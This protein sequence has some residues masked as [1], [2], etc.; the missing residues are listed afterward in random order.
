MTRPKLAK[1]RG[2]HLQ[3][4][5][6]ARKELTDSITSGDEND[7]P[8]PLVLSNAKRNT[9]KSVFVSQ[10]AE[11][12]AEIA[13]NA[14]L[15]TELESRVSRL[16][17]DLLQFHIEHQHLVESLT[18]RRNDLEAQ[19]RSLL[20][21]TRS[22]GRSLG[23]RKRKAET[24]FGTELVRK[25]KRIKRLENERDVKAAVIAGLAD[26]IDQQAVYIE[27]LQAIACSSRRNSRF[28]IVRMSASSDHM[29]YVGSRAG[30]R[31][32]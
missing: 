10:I 19:N 30:R 23:Q 11:K 28:I 25:Q 13:R 20:T 17:A 14:A 26:T 9:W 5:N 18:E 2:K 21:E 27:D 3:Q 29:I 31:N 22:L 15:I 4:Y 6:K 16:E 24:A 8:A 32:R 1:Q 12:D 7:P